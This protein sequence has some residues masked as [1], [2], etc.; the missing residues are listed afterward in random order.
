MRE[1]LRPSRMLVAAFAPSNS[2]RRPK[3]QASTR[4][5]VPK[6]PTRSVAVAL[7]G[8]LKAGSDSS[9]DEASVDEVGKGEKPELNASIEQVTRNKCE[10][11]KK[12]STWSTPAGGTRATEQQ[13]GTP[14]N[15]HRRLALGEDSIIKNN[16]GNGVARAPRSVDRRSHDSKSPSQ[17]LTSPG[18]KASAAVTSSP[19]SSSSAS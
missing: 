11:A 18:S 12:R 15:A 10:R 7:H 9:L 16:K 14:S 4:R 3:Q 19:L 17:G 13:E 8:G 2:V 6:T 1:M 5:P